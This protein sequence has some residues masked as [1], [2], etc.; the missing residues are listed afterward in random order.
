MKFFESDFSGHNNALYAICF[1][2]SKLKQSPVYIN[3]PPL[4]VY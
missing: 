3:R 1:R 4:L 2:N